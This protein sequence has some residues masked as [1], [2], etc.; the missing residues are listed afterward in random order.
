MQ[1]SGP[2]NADFPGAF[3]PPASA[4][5]E[6]ACYAQPRF[7]PPLTESNYRDLWYAAGAWNRRASHAAVPGRQQS[8]LALLDRT[9]SAGAVIPPDGSIWA[10]GDEADAYASLAA[11]ILDDWVAAG[12]PPIQAWQVTL[13][14]AGPIWVPSSYQVPDRRVR[15]GRPSGS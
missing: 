5:A 8:C 4:L 3:P 11:G 15:H 13:E 10:G 6:L 14:L 9:G 2:L 12:R 7:D 1:A